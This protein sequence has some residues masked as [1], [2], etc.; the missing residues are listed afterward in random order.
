MNF[1]EYQE[2]SRKT[3]LFEHNNDELRAVLGLVGESGEVAEKYKKK[4][5]C[6]EKYLGPEGDF[7]FRMEMMQEVGDVLY[8]LA[9]L[10]DYSGFSLMDV[11]I[12]NIN[13]L[14]SRKKRGK[15]KGSGDSR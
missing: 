12:E 11:A 5:R 9:R 10:C 13:K 4:L 8:Y 7:V 1:I 14:Q 3:W 6:D 15:L 2:K